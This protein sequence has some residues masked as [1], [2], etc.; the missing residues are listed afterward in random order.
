MRAAFEILAISEPQ[1]GG[2]RIAVLGDMLELGPTADELHAGLAAALL[3]SGVDLVFTAGAAHEASARGRCRATSA[4]A[5]RKAP[6][7]SRR[8]S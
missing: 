8:S 1:A 4:A 7:R 5:M 3:A 6:R 2:R